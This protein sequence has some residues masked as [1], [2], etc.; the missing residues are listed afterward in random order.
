MLIIALISCNSPSQNKTTPNNKL[1][2]SLKAEKNND[3]SEIVLTIKNNGNTTKHLPLTVDITSSILSLTFQ[4]EKHERL[5]TIP[6]SIPNE[7]IKIDTL[8]LYPNDEHNIKYNL[9]IFSPTLTKGTYKATLRKDTNVFCY[10]N[11]N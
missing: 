8:Q 7:N 9:N 11:I 3:I 6:P 10:F 2:Y 1:I 4:N 5:L